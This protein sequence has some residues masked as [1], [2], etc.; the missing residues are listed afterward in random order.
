MHRSIVYLLEMVLAG[1]ISSVKW[2]TVQREHAPSLEP[3]LGHVEEAYGV[4]AIDPDGYIQHSN[5]FNSGDE[6]VAMR[7]W[8]T[9]LVDEGSRKK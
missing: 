4:D 7:L 3:L 5:L 8:T 9:V 1:P 6:K 2:T